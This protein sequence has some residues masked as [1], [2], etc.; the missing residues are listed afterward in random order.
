MNHK[1]FANSI[2]VV[3]IV[4]VLVGVVGY[5]SFVQKSKLTA[6]QPTLTPTQTNVSTLIETPAVET[7]NWLS[8]DS[9]K[10]ADVKSHFSFK[11]PSNWIQKGSIDGG[12]ASA[13]PFYDKDAYSEKCDEVGG[14]VTTCHTTGQV[15]RALV[16]GPSVS[17]A[18]IEYNFEIKEV[19]TIDGYQ[20]TKIIGS[21]KSDVE[22]N[23]YIGKPGQK[24]MRVIIPNINGM[25]FEFTMLIESKAD[26]AAF[27][28]ILKT[29]VFKI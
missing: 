11:H 24:E 6:Q 4:T 8:F 29:I 21:V 19:I 18:K 26:E 14:G 10:D 12:A 13:I 16:S 3:A 5:F 2:L 28:E 15:A 9:V 23:A 1:G 27:N 25:R 20:G 17:P 22:L 7:T